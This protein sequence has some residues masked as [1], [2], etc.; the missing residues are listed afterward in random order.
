MISDDAYRPTIKTL[1]VTLKRVLHKV[2][3]SEALQPTLKTLDITLRSV[4]LGK[5][6]NDGGAWQPTL[7]TLDIELYRK[8]PMKVEASAESA[9]QSTLK[10]L[11]IELH[12]LLIQ[13]S[14]L[15]DSAVQPTLK[16]LD[17][18][19]KTGV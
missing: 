16:T 12:R 1:D 18:T 19:L 5:A 15:D 6:I 4:V 10:T 7:K 9:W 2:D 11:D 17:I 8:P 14:V 3:L 13:H